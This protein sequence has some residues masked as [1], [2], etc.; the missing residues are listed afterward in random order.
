MI[1]PYIACI[2]AINI[3]KTH[4]D[5][6]NFPLAV[7]IFHNTIIYK[8]CNYIKKGELDLNPPTSASPSGDRQ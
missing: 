4:S 3:F 5:R 6:H 1:P 7:N 2:T 8:N